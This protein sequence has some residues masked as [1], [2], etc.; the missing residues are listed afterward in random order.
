MSKNKDS[1]IDSIKV[2]VG[3][4]AYNEENNI[5]ALLDNLLNRQDLPSNSEIIVVCSGC[6]DFTP[7]IVRKFCDKNEQIRLIVEDKRRGK[8]SALNRILRAYQGDIFVNI[9]ADH[10]PSP[11]T[12]KLL[13]NDLSDPRIGA[14]TGNKIPVGEDEFMDKIQYTAWG[15]HAEANRLF[16]RYGKAH[17]GGVLFA[18]RRGICNRIPDDVVND[19]A[20]LEI[21]CRQKGYQVHYEDRA[22]AFFSCLRTISE[23]IAHR[24]RII[25]G[26]LK[27][28]GKTGEAPMILELA[29]LKDRF[30]I[31]SRWIRK[32]LNL[33]PHF[34]A[35]C[36]LEIWANI[37]ARLDSRKV[38]NP[39]K[40][41]RT[42]QTDKEIPLLKMKR[43]RR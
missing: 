39:H 29:S 7:E 41:W 5:E 40:I 3:I 1:E 35:L 16:S 18:I 21:M 19:D 32:N 43:K 38:Y 42:S 23:F 28:K 26:H 10:I 33:V 14:V 11:G 37:L 9:D 12:I 4:C 24:R 15:L 30:M 8:I 20:Y 22:F 2:S 36:L 17:L 31:I 34:L 6:N 27:I 25:Y 13:L